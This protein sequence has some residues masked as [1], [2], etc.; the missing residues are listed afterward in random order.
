[1]K[2]GMWINRAQK[3]FYHSPGKYC[4]MMCLWHSSS[5]IV[6]KISANSF[7]NIHS[8]SWHLFLV[9][10]KICN[11]DILSSERNIATAAVR[12]TFVC[13]IGSGLACSRRKEQ[14]I[15][16]VCDINES[17]TWHKNGCKWLPVA[18]NKV[19]CCV[20]NYFLCVVMR[21]YVCVCEFK[22]K[23]VLIFSDIVLLCHFVFDSHISTGCRRRI[24]HWT[25]TYIFVD[26]LE[27]VDF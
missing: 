15:T 9:I 21:E 5:S 26:G 2:T 23:C 27:Y 24:S 13:S 12:I 11:Q 14:H 25:C 17:I 20:N 6:S 7:C 18:F 10:Y 1:M 3:P 4:L 22:R 19:F 8:T 16:F